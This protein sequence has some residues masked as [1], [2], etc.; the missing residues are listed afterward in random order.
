MAG[1]DL[2]M[3]KPDLSFGTKLLAKDYHVLP[4]TGHLKRPTISGWHTYDVAECREAVRRTTGLTGMTLKPDP[5][6]PAQLVILDFDKPSDQEAP[7]CTKAVA[8]ALNLGTDISDDIPTVRTVSGGLHLYFR[9]KSGELLP[10]TFDLQD[11]IKGDVR[12]SS[13]GKHLIVLPGTVADGKVGRGRYEWLHGAPN[14]EDWPVIPDHI[15]QILGR[16]EP[17]V[18]AGK[19]TELRDVLDLLQMVPGNSVPDGTWT[20][21]AFNLGRIYGRIWAREQPGD[22]C[23]EEARTAFQRF[24]RGTVDG[25][26]FAR[27]F[28]NGYAKGRTNAGI[29]KPTNKPPT[30]TDAMTEA[31]GLFGARPWL[32]QQETT[33]GRVSAMIMGLGDSKQ[34]EVVGSFD[35][36][37]VLSDLARMA[38]C[39]LDR[40]ALSPLF[41]E[42]KWFKAL[43]L[44]MLT[45]AKRLQ[46]GADP[47]ESL[48]TALANKAREAAAAGKSGAGLLDGAPDGKGA[49]LWEQR[50]GLTL[51]VS[52][53]AMQQVMTG[54]SPK[55]RTILEGLGECKRSAHTGKLW[56][57]SLSDI[58]PDGSMGLTTVVT[59]RL[60]AAKLKKNK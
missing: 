40:V 50:G 23:I 3:D 21:R 53:L 2:L 19:P 15:S 37:T 51:V 27:E 42:P 31:H 52:S 28:M 22:K 34:E 41:L 11:G 17:P 13:D 55:C 30:A 24:A 38:G 8:L 7:V 25:D 45:E 35:Q 60:A 44:A 48:I 36:V 29:Y 39:E 10:Q 26:V 46:V 33:D 47:H 12:Q 54:L 14:P 58:D 20:M 6:D 5:R 57:I 4:L 43:R 59:Q 16:T 18:I 56:R 32:H 1:A 49:W 9:A